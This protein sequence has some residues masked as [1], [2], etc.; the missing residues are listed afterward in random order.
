MHR[1]N[2]VGQKMENISLSFHWLLCPNAT[3]VLQALLLIVDKLFSQ[4]CFSGHNMEDQYLDIN[5]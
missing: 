1:T 3:H 2:K 4:K 5:L